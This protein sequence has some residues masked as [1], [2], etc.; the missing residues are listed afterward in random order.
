MVMV[1]CD[2]DGDVGDDQLPGHT[3]SNTLVFVSWWCPQQCIKWLTVSIAG[4]LPLVVL[5]F[6][7]SS[8][9]HDVMAIGLS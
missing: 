4:I 9:F 2:G 5:Q 7:L 1:T 3:S 8:A 6:F